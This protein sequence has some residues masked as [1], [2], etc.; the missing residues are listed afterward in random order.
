MSFHRWQEGGLSF[1]RATTLVFMHK[2]LLMYPPAREII[3]S[4]IGQV[5]IA[6]FF[7]IA[8]FSITRNQK[9]SQVKEYILYITIPI[10][11]VKCL[12]DQAFVHFHTLLLHIQPS[13]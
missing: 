2:V 9:E 3:T 5:L 7:Q 12:I 1:G 4:T 10:L 6:R 13:C 8:S 11:L